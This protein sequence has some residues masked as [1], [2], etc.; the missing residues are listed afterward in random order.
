MTHQHDIRGFDLL[1]LAGQY[2]ALRWSAST[3]GGEYKGACPQCGGRDRLIVQPA[4]GRDGRGQWTCR[5]CR[6]FKWGDAVDFALWQGLAADFRGACAALKLD[7]ADRDER[8]VEPPPPPA[9]EPPNEVWRAR[10]DDLCNSAV[11]VL[12]D[13]TGAR[14]RSWLA[15]RGIT[16]HTM[17]SAGL[18]YCPEDTFDD[19]AVWGLPI[20]HAR[21]YTPRGI[22]IPWRIGGEVWRVNVR[23]PVTPAQVAAG[24]AK[25]RGPAGSSNALYG[26]DALKPGRPAL[27]VEGELDALSV[28]QEARKLVDVV[29]LGST[30]GARRVRWLARLSLCSLVLVATDNEEP[31]EAAARYWIDALGG[32]ARRWRPTLK[33][34][35]QML[36][37]GMSIA[38]W[39]AVGLEAQ[40]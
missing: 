3:R 8:I 35:N 12:W 32:N 31:G 22:V 9:T 17:V 30:T 33:D 20:E 13:D 27:I 39:V 23:R 5:S 4:G 25:Y 19:P 2:T 38:E 14:A 1:A 21:V 18:G 36:Q 24:E 28:W 15:S 37:E 10:A 6:E 40:S 16:E 11:D 26:A 34:T 7:I 29:A